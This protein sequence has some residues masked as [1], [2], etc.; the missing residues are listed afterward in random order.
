MKK[1]GKK[2]T[3]KRIIALLV[4]AAVLILTMRVA[5]VFVEKRLNSIRTV[6]SADVTAT[7]VPKQTVTVSFQDETVEIG[8]GLSCQLKATGGE[9]IV[10]RTSDEAVA[11]VDEK[12]M[13]TG[14][15][16]GECSITAENEEGSS[17]VCKVTVKKTC[18]LTVDDGPTEN[19]E[20]I[21]KVLKEN[22]VRATFFVVHSPQL[23]LT[24]NMQDQGCV[25]GLHSYSHIFVKCYATDYSYF[26][27]LD[28]LSDAVEQYTG[29]RPNL[30]RFPGGT[31]NTRCN[32]LR[33]R[34]ILNGAYDFGYRPFDWTSTTAD[35]SKKASAKYSFDNVKKSCVRDEE[36]ILMH[37]R[38][39]NVEALK[40]IIPYL[41]KQG[42]IFETLDHYPRD[43]FTGKPRYSRQHADSPATAVK[44]THEYFSIYKGSSFVLVAKMTPI[45]S[46][47]YVRWESSDPSIAEVKSSGC[48]Y[49]IS[50]GTVD[51]YAI[52]SSGQRGVCHLTV[53]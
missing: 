41:R 38:D 11:T 20:A 26:Y 33:M 14:A 19:T 32:L 6:S 12:G 36:I 50:K 29:T 53:K 7:D 34:R 43:S 18:Y 3:A 17:A 21:L 25:V 47:D 44:I 13:I 45:D 15:G 30:I 28:L 8:K 51:I 22:H 40:K 42:Y 16:V 9:R 48:V 5:F 52:T 39:F 10:Y 35:T 23:Y 4:T 27:G 24:K 49:G 1:H 37:D 46:T 31:H 2:S